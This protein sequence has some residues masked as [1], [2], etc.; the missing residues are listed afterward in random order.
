MT[1]QA[2]ARSPDD[3]GRLGEH[4]A[5]LAEALAHA[6][7]A[8]LDPAR[9]V[10]FAARA[11]PHTEHC[12]LTLVRGQRRPQT[13]ASTGEL[14]RAVDA[15]QYAVR[16]GPC[17]EATLSDE[18]VV[19]E[20]LARDDRWPQFARRCV[21][22]TGVHSMLSLRLT[23]GG[24]DRAAMNFYSARA[25]VFTGLDVGL[26]SMFAPFA[27]LAVQ[28]GVHVEDV[29]NLEKAL[30]S[31]RQIGTAIGILMAREY[32]TSDQAFELLREASQHLNRKLRDIA[33]EVELTGELPEAVQ[34]HLPGEQHG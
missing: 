6:P 32:L 15:L 5:E 7:S 18:A 26:A 25:G 33:A 22:E 10:R 34:E 16:E 28:S 2:D 11:V 20:D 24:Q 14:P 12:G 1:N 4:F 21:A 8:Q 23:L 17:L 19:V 27:A 30:T 9:L 29:D 13:V 3:M 31:S